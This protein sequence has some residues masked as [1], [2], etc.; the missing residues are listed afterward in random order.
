MLVFNSEMHVTTL[1]FILLELMMLA[2]Q[3]YHYRLA[4]HDK[5]R[6]W[7]L[8][9]LG[10]L[11]FYNITGGLFPDPDIPF[12][13]SLQNTVA[14]GAGFLIAA[15]FPYYFYKSFNL[16]YLRFQALYGTTVFL[17][18]P[19]FVFFVLIYSFNENLDF[20]INYGLIIP[21][22]YSLYLLWAILDAIK[23]EFK[24][25]KE[26]D[27][28]SGKMEILSVYFAVFPWVCLSVFAYFNISQ[29]IEVLVTNAG[30]ILVTALS[31][32]RSIDRDRI[33]YE[34]QLNHRDIQ[35]SNFSKKCTDYQL[36]VREQEIA[37]LVCQGL[38]YKE[39]GRILFISKKTVDAHIRK[40]FQKTSSRNKIELVRLLGLTS[41]WQ[42]AIGFENH[43]KYNP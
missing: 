13:L 5:P 27:G 25:K 29:W 10:L 37:R 35:I 41:A 1:L 19:Y 30:F 22:I 16:R 36:S 24:V 17:L 39:M 4:P 38:T 23:R 3:F 14:Y 11:I 20:A 15:Y 8:I 9:L 26:A 6:L 33:Q 2:V 34:R 43:L 32:K 31:L 28:I 12:S 18:G 42:E 21:F 7:Y 40:I